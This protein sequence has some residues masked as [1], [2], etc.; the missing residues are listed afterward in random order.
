MKKFVIWVMIGVLLLS[1]AVATAMCTRDNDDVRRTYDE[2]Q[3]IAANCQA[4]ISDQYFSGCYFED[5]QTD[6]R[7]YV[8]LT[9]LSAAPEIKNERVKFCEVKYSLKE[10]EAYQDAVW[11]YYLDKG[12]CEA[13]IAVKENKVQFGFE[14]GTDVS[15]LYALIPKDAVEYHFPGEGDRIE[16][17][18]DTTKDGN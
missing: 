6:P 16:L 5:A 13:W 18:S 4:N 10:L 3:A 17:V 12:C 15:A 14:K 9:D 11:S 2:L 8:L 7:L 1:A